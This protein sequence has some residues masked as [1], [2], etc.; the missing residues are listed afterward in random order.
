MLFSSTQQRVLGLIFG[1]PA[2]SFTVS[3][4]ISLA[5]MGS[6]AVQREIERLART[7]LVTVDIVEG[8]KKYRANPSSPIFS[9]LRSIVEKTVGV[10][11]Q[12]RSAL[13]PVAQTIRAAILFGS[14]AKKSDRAGSDI[15]ILVVSDDLSLEEIYRLMAPVEERLGRRVSPTVYTA[16]EFESR[17]R[18]GSAFLKKLLAGEHHVLIEEGR[19]LEGAGEPREDGKAQG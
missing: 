18:G 8:R 4:L 13:L 5:Q 17:K 14:V 1:Q 12:V 3:E 2:R 16:R 6:G 7:E 9:E 11:E 19:G 10:A 15:D